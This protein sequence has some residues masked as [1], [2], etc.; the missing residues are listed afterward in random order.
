[1]GVKSSSNRF[2]RG[3]S[4]E[5]MKPN[6]SLPTGEVMEFVRFDGVEKAPTYKM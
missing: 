6:Y 5:V 3:Y 2:A 4:E 1:M